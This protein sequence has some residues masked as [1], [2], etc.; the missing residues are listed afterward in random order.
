M[1]DL[2]FEERQLLDEAIVAGKALGRPFTEREVLANAR[3]QGYALRLAF[4][5]RFVKVSERRGS[6]LPLWTVNEDQDRLNRCYMA[7]FFGALS[8]Y[9]RRC[10]SDATGHASET[11]NKAYAG[12]GP[13]PEM[14]SRDELVRDY[15]ERQGWTFES[16]AQ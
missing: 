10:Y 9:A 11:L 12:V 15:L 4:D 3:Q 1:A 2:S 13:R 14:P 5:H 16:E 8:D 7:D 6:Q